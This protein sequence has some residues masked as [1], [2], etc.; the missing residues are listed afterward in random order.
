MKNIDSNFSEYL[1]AFT[2]FYPISHLKKD[3]M[4]T[5]YYWYEKNILLIKTN[6]W[7]N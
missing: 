1:K 7:D 6:K 5:L 4:K 3:K 2:Q